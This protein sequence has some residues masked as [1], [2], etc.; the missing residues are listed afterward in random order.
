MAVLLG[1]GAYYKFANNHRHLPTG[2]DE[3]GYLYLADAM[4]QGRTFGEHTERPY[5]PELIRDLEKEGFTYAQYGW[6]LAPHAYHCQPDSAQITNQYPPGTS[7]VLSLFPWEQR[8]SYF[9]AWVAVLFWILPLL[10]LGALAL[11]RLHV[12]AVLLFTLLAFSLLSTPFLT[13]YSRI[14][15]VAP[16]FGLLVAAG[17]CLFTRPGWSIVFIACAALFR[18]PNVWLLI[19]VGLIYLSKTWHLGWKERFVRA[20]KAIALGSLGGIAWLAAYQYK[21]LGNPLTSTYSTRDQGW[22]SLSEL[23]KQ[24]HYYLIAEPGWTSVHVVGFVVLLWAAQT[25]RIS[26]KRVSVT[27]GIVIWNYLFFLAH[28]VQVPYYPYATAL[29]VWGIAIDAFRHDWLSLRTSRVVAA[30]TMLAP[31]VLI[32]VHRDTSPGVQ[33]QERAS[34]QHCLADAEVVWA[35]DRSGTLEYATGKS[36]LR[37]LWGDQPTRNFVLRW[38]REHGIRQ[39]IWLDEFPGSEEQASVL[40][41][42]W[43]LPHTRKTCETWGT[44]LEIPPQ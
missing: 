32:A 12:G 34:L 30:I 4:N 39:W 44:F 16:T 29:L 25:G 33:A 1:L 43:N 41:N 9:P 3:F 11:N 2:C 18:L 38:F 35:E 28:E 17:I 15:A 31:I 13:E 40:L 24:L 14:N 26:W 8:Q 23:G 19:P 37:L 10:A 5:L 27:L 7:A 6:I 36:G 21:L 42:Q 20:G 22:I